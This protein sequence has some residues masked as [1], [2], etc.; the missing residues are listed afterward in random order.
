MVTRGKYVRL[1]RGI[2]KKLGAATVCGIV[3]APTIHTFILV[4]ASP[5]V[6]Y[7]AFRTKIPRLLAEFLG[8]LISLLPIRSPSISRVS[9]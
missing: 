7:K 8:T 6:Y 4:R 3:S 9:L 2:A 5:N 1:A